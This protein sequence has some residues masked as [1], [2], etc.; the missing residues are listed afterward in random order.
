VAQH[1]EGGRVSLLARLDH[2]LVGATLGADGLARHHSW[3]VARGLRGGLTAAHEALWRVAAR[4]GRAKADPA[5]IRAAWVAPIKDAPRFPLRA[6]TAVSPAA[7]ALLEGRY[8]IDGELSV[9]L[10]EIS[11]RP[12]PI[13]RAASP[14]VGLVV[15]SLEGIRTLVDAYRLTGRPEYLETAQLVAR[16]WIAECLHAERSAEI[17]SDHI[18]ALRAL[19]LCQ[20]WV[21]SKEDGGAP[22]PFAGELFSGLERHAVKLAHPRFHRFEHNHG[23]TQAYAL[24]ALGVCL[25]PHPD[26]PQ[27][28]HLGRERLEA[29]MRDNVSPEGVH[30]EHSPAY[31]LYVL[32]QFVGAARFAR[33]HCMPLSAEFEERLRAMILCSAHMLRPDGALPALGDGNTGSP[34]HVVPDDLVEWA[35]EAVDAFTYAVS[36]GA[37]GR[38]PSASDVILPGGGS[39]FLRSDWAPGGGPHGG[40]FVALR[41]A[42]FPTAHIHRDVLSFE[43]FAHGADLVVDTGGPGVYPFRAWLKSTPAHNTVAVDGRD[44]AIGPARLITTQQ[45][46]GGVL[47]DAEHALY[48]GVRHRRVLVF[49]RSGV[50]LLLDHLQSTE[51]HDYALHLHLAPALT[52]VPKGLAVRCRSASGGAGLRV[53]ALLDDGL[54]IDVLR[55]GEHAGQ[56]WIQAGPALTLPSTVLRYRR[57]KGTVTFVTL[58][59]PEPAGLSREPRWTLT[60]RPFIDE[61]A[62]TLQV[63][64]DAWGI[65]LSAA[66]DVSMSDNRGEAR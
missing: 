32:L 3:R 61:T 14:F 33:A 59:V 27:W 20:L 64:D 8:P 30:L 17:W 49:R 40:A 47:I 35:G 2:W 28:I 4:A 36:R 38:A 50:V 52:P 31:Q 16:R 6:A 18:T 66:G 46:A 10:T 56:G 12:P 37:A 53:E 9:P 34:I 55:G 58:L 29:Q 45:A 11:W 60:G 1:A 21:A 39:V 51:P 19:T 23:V 7:T 15:H 13:P 44:Q 48:P 42:T 22:P 57:R 5:L 54:K 63:G 25:A 65:R 43:L 41:L 26:A 24:L 62:L